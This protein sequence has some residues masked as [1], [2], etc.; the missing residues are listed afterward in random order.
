VNDNLATSILRKMLDAGSSSQYFSIETSQ[1]GGS[2]II[3][4]LSMNVSDEEAA[5]LARLRD[6][7]Q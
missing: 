5:Y 3:V 4:D 1:A 2:W 6:E 7:G